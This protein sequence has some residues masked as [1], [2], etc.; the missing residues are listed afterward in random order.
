MKEKGKRKNRHRIIL[1][2]YEKILGKLQLF[3]TQASLDVS[4]TG[5][6]KS[7]LN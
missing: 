6:S 7:N 3:N 4:V 1:I 5:I 2:A